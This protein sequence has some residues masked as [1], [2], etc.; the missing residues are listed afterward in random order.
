MS[1]DIPKIMVVDDEVKLLELIVSILGGLPID[2][3][4]AKTGEEGLNILR[5]SNEFAVT[6]SNYYMGSGMNGG[7]F[8]KLV[9]EY[10]P[11]TVRILMTG[12]IDQDSLLAKVKGGEIEDFAMKP[13]MVD[14]FICQVK[15]SIQEYLSK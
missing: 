2:I 5:N 3:T 13:V 6:I 4:T 15:R 7:E 8:L 1:S 12:G 9:R 10:S 11:R 14:N